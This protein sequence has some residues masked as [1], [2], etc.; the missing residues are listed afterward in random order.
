MFECIEN[1][2]SHA[3]LTFLLDS[4]DLDKQWPK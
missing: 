2:N 3:Q 4:I 1:F